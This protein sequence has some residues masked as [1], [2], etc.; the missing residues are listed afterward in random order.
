[1][2]CCKQL[3]CTFS[4]VVITVYQ[5]RVCSTI[6]VVMCVGMTLTTL[7]IRYMAG[8]TGLEPVTS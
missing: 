1:M 2:M 4:E 5:V 3:Q 7:D 8:R 6:V